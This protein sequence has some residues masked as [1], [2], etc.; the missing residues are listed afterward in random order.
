MDNREKKI[1]VELN[2]INHIYLQAESNGTIQNIYFRYNDGYVE[3]LELAAANKSEKEKIEEIN[4]MFKAMEVSKVKGRDYSVDLASAEIFVELK[5]AIAKQEQAKESEYNLNLETN[6]NVYNLET[7]QDNDE[8][9]GFNILEKL[10]VANLKVADDERLEN[11]K[12]SIDEETKINSKKMAISAAILGLAIAIGAGAFAY[13]RFGK[14]EEEIVEAAAPAITR[15]VEEKISID[16]QDWEFYLNN[17]KDSNQKAAMTAIDNY[18]IN[19]NRSEDWMYEK[20]TPEM[21]E[22]LKK[23]NIIV[24]GDEAIFGFTAEQVFALRLV[25]GHD[26]YEELTTMMNGE[27]I[28]VTKTM[29]SSES[30]MNQAIRAQIVYLLNSDNTHS[31]IEELMGLTDEEKEQ[32]EPFLNLFQEYKDLLKE[33]KYTE[34]EKKM[35]EIKEALVE[36]AHNQDAEVNNAKPWILRTILPAASIY[37]TSYGY[38]D[39]IT[40][41]LYDG[42]N[43]KYVDKEVKTWLFD[44][45][46]M[47]D[48]VEGYKDCIGEDGLVYQEGFNSVEFLKQFNISTQQYSIVVSDDGV[49]IADEFVG[50]LENRL[51]EAN[52]FMQ[53]LREE[54]G[55][56]DA[57][58]TANSTEDVNIANN[59][60]LDELTKDT[61]NSEQV[62]ELINDNL[63][64]EN[65]YPKN[66][67]FFTSI[68]SKFTK[69]VIAFKDKMAAK[70]SGKKQ[71]NTKAN[72]QIVKVIPGRT[73]YV[74]GTSY[75]VTWTETWTEEYTDTRV[76]HEKVSEEEIAKEDAKNRAKAVEEASKTTVTDGATGKEKETTYQDIYNRAV[77]NG[78]DNKTNLDTNLDGDDKTNKNDP[79]VQKV[80]K[81]ADE[82]SKQIN[83]EHENAKN[84]NGGAKEVKV[85]EQGN[86]HYISGGDI[87]SETGYKVEEDKSGNVTVKDSNTGA[88]L[89]TATESEAERYNRELAERKAQETANQANNNNNNN[90]S[91]NNSNSDN[92][93]NES[94]PA[95]VVEEN[96]AGS[97]E[98]TTED[99]TT[100]DTFAPVEETT[101]FDTSSIESASPDMLNASF[102]AAP[103]E[104]SNIFEGFTTE[105]PTTSETFA[106]AYEEEIDEIIESLANEAPAE[107]ASEGM[108]R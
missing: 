13:N 18:V 22:E 33:E 49:S 81:W 25:F 50:G 82:D 41:N 102:M 54:N 23:A 79:L 73:I 60:D 39:T 17:V 36:Y 6:K 59:S 105:D 96:T 67:D 100:S 86:T 63:K 43:D 9:K 55:K 11:E 52:N 29:S 88:K 91:N 68:Y 90:N 8:I 51:N 2:Q 64:E 74:P 3:L 87:K 15:E 4:K 94:A 5:E 101:T 21:I 28:D 42:K 72:E 103:A 53:R 47:R 65:K 40:L 38:M 95:P 78:T 27:Y 20:L 70:F 45:I 66:L 16:G 83:Q 1:G 69:Q 57:Y 46:T 76:E 48:L 30:L 92:S 89:D 58:V 97:G 26:S 71:G 61:Y 93:N 24:D 85:D 98:Y 62:L 7:E 14:K 77:N 34:A 44:E 12:F 80:E 10:G 56:I 75:T 106:P 32:V 107:E 37:A 108:S 84:Y 35:K 104:E 31:G 99:P 19:F